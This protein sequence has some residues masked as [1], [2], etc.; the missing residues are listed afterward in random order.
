MVYDVDRFDTVRESESPDFTLQHR[1]EQE[2]FG[3]EATEF[4]LT[5]S[6]AR[7]RNIPGYMSSLFAGGQARHRDDVDA[8][9]QVVCTRRVMETREI[10]IRVDAEAAKAYAAASPEEREKLEH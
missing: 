2:C 8:L 5:D 1:N 6:D 3:V 4:Y 9:L 10:T 7:I